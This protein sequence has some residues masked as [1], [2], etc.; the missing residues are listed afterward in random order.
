MA[1]IG[2][3]TTQVR[4]FRVSPTRD[5]SG[6]R[7]PRASGGQLGPGPDRAADPDHA[8]GPTPCARARRELRRPLCVVR[9]GRPVSGPGP[10]WPPDGEAS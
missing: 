1:L 9:I 2:P 5:G 8:Y 4:F 3:R 7:R 6:L 10:S